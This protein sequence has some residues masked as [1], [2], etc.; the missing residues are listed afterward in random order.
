MHF[1]CSCP[2]FVD[3][4]QVA[5]T[6]WC[7]GRSLW[8]YLRLHA[9]FRATCQEVDSGV[10]PLVFSLVS[11]ILRWHHKNHLVRQPTTSKNHFLVQIG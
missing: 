6:Y 9:F 2:A 8:V 5:D 4:L 10:C 11:C 7:N 1:D 3:V